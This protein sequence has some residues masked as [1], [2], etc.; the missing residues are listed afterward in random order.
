MPETPDREPWTQAAPAIA[1]ALPDLCF[2]IGP[3]LRFAACNHP[4]HPDLHAP[5]AT[6]Q[7]R[8]L[9]S[10]GP[11]AL[12]Q[13]FAAACAP[14]SQRLRYAL[15]TQSGRLAR[16]EASIAPLLDGTG[17]LCMARDL[18]S[19]DAEQARYARA[20]KGAADGLWEWDIA[21]DSEYLSPRALT[22]LD[23]PGRLAEQLQTDD[24]G[25]WRAALQS[26]LQH[27]APLDIDLRLAGAAT[28]WLRCRGWTERDAR[29]QPARVLATL[30]DITIAKFTEQAL[31]DSQA[32][33][34]ALFHTVPVGIALFDVASET[35]IESN[36]EL[37]RLL[38]WP[39]LS[40]VGQTAEAL[41]LAPLPGTEGRTEI[42]DRELHPV[43]GCRLHAKL[44]AEPV[45]LAGRALLLCAVVDISVQ[46]DAEAA[47][48]AL[49]EQLMDQERRTTQR[50]AQALHDQLGQT[51]TALRL[52]LDLGAADARQQARGLIDQA[53]REV[54]Q[55]L[56]DLRPPLLEDEGLAAALDNEVAQRRALH[57]GVRLVLD[58]EDE[59]L[60]QRWP[61]EV[62]YALFMIAREGLENAL[63]HARPTEVRLSFYGCAQ[64]IELGVADDGSGLDADFERRPGHLGLIGMRERAR[65]IGATLELGP[66]EGGGTQLTLRWSVPE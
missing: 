29:G 36:D 39:T 31:T 40:V 7:G 38:G 2:L 12:A 54:R 55:V 10:I 34:R 65:A 5:W 41:G 42:D 48:S 14:S 18:G 3:D 46:V 49:A 8:S 53:L 28:R 35:V 64:E 22:L 9:Q 15:R 23:R 37:G 6:L 59:L 20:M 56:V 30:S 45:D 21:A 26:H 32:K 43:S 62:E 57:P 47:L 63:R 27:G 4:D 17:W 25:Q 1:A 61:V 52:M 58:A 16:F 19:T 60:T 50:L 33:F 13:Q 51:L 44:V 66:R 11:P 24:Q